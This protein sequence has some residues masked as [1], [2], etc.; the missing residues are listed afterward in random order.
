MPAA[1]VS[2]KT[3][4]A[5]LCFSIIIADL[6]ADLGK[7]AGLSGEFFLCLPF[8]MCIR[9]QVNAPLTP[10][11]PRCR[12]PP[13]GALGSRDNILVLMSLFTIL[14]LCLLRSFAAL[15]ATAYMGIA[16][17]I[18]TIIAMVY[19]LME[20]SYAPGG[21]FYQAVRVRAP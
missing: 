15:S 9:V 17:T 16:G 6:S 18:G 14:P 12:V 11:R 3:L 20:G 21:Q 19:R 7:T 5:C 2:F 10:R 4:V 13:S 1:T 8:G